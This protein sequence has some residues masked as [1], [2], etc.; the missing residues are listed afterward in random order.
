MITLDENTTGSLGLSELS[1][2]K[3]NIR[4]DQIPGLFCNQIKLI[5]SMVFL[6]ILYPGI[7]IV[8]IKPHKYRV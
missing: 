4:G 2:I 5:F 3:Y 6:F 7:S 1:K 8:G